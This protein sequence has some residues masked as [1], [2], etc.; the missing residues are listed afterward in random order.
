MMKDKKPGEV[1]NRPQKD[2]ARGLRC[3]EQLRDHIEK[4]GDKWDM[5]LPLFL[6]APSIARLLWFNEIYKRSINVC[7]NIVEFGS[8]WGASFNTLLMLRLIYEPW[9]DAKKLYSFSNFDNGLADV[10]LLDGVKVYDGDYATT[11]QWKNNLE[12]ILSNHVA[13]RPNSHNEI[14]KIIEGDAEENFS[15]W[16]EDNPHAIFSLVH[17]DLD[18]Y[19]PTKHILQKIKSRAPRGSIIVFDELNC[20]E[21][22]GETLAVDEVFGIENLKL[23]KTQFQPY[24]TFFIVE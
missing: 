9:N 11:T 10:T 12:D 4:F 21:L 22:P 20:K 19:K 24:S 23:Q 8:Q 5:H 18:V 17:F 13:N 6:T 15:D 1:T 2:L 3:R 7:G 14:F 16:L